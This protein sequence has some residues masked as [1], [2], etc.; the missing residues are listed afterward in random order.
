MLTKLPLLGRR[1][2]DGRLEIVSQ[3]CTAQ[4]RVGRPTD[5]DAFVAKPSQTDS[6][7]PDPMSSPH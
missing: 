3:G 5:D 7:I 4:Q 2:S 6:H 1:K